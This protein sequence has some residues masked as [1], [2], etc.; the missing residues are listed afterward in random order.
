VTPI[1]PIR[2]LFLQSVPVCCWGVVA[3]FS[4]RIDLIRCLRSSDREEGSLGDA[5]HKGGASAPVPR[6]NER[7]NE[8]VSIQY[9]NTWKIRDADCFKTKFDDGCRAKRT[10]PKK[11]LGM[12]FR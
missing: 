8:F 9:R 7:I 12:L 2:K 5:V 10:C 11:A 6:A 3:L 4:P 1:N